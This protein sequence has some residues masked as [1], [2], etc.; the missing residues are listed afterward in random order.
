MITRHHVALALMCSLIIVTAIVPFDP[1]LLLALAAGT[2][3]GAV[4]PDIQMTRPKKFCV[5]T[6]AWCIVRFTTRLCVPVMCRSYRMIPGFRADPRD[7]RL[8]HSVPGILAIF[9][10]LAGILY[11]FAVLAGQFHPPMMFN[12]FLAGAFIG[13]ALHLAEDLCTRKGIAPFFPFC[14]LHLNGSI[15]PCDTGDRRIGQFHVQHCSVL[16]G[17]LA[18]SAAG[19]IPPGY[20][21]PAGLIGS[22]ACVVWMISLSSVKISPGDTQPPRAPNGNPAPS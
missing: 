10:I 12:A 7:K 20:I 15:R 14:D 17:F 1:G 6:L 19:M 5:R 18:L 22:I 16:V 11:G 21:L 4:L 3:I 8:T 13:M 2:C 9:G